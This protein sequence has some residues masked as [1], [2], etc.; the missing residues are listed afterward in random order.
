MGGEREG[1]PLPY[2]S[3]KKI[4][5]NIRDGRM[6]P[7]VNGGDVGG[8]KHRKGKYCLAEALRAR[9][10]KILADAT[11][12]TLVIDGWRS[13]LG[14]RPDGLNMIHPNMKLMLIE[15]VLMHG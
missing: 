8:Y 1:K 11:S 9:L 4:V 2:D 5:D 6:A 13:H 7:E 10:R 3:F 14:M 12:L 15:Y